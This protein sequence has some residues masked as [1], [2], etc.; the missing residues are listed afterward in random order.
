VAVGG[1]VDKKARN[2]SKHMDD[3]L[4]NETFLLEVVV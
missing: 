2:R 4:A 3:L 1:I